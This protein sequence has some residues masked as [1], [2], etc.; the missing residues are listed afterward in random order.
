LDRNVHS[1]YG[2]IDII[3]MDL[4]EVV[5]VEVKTRTRHSLKSAENSVTHAKQHRL[6]LTA[7]QYLSDN[8]KYSNKSCRF[9]VII[10]LHYPQDDS[11]AIK[12]HKNAFLPVLPENQIS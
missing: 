6:S 5:F 12:H 8:S 4:E 10:V 11:Y 7:L 1:A 3:A 9:D 2:E